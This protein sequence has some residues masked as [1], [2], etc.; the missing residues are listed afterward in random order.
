M[1]GSKLT[2]FLCTGRN[3]LLL[4]WG[5]MDLIFLFLVVVWMVEIYFISEW[6]IGVGLISKDRI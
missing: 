1:R 5:S 4:E 6:G 3:D 2:G